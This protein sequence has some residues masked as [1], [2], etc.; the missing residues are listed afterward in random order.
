MIRPVPLRELPRLP[1]TGALVI[2][3]IGA[4][5]LE[6]TGRD[7]SALT[8]DVRA[9]ETEPWRL[10]T[11]ALPHVGVIH[12]AFNLYWIWTFGARVEERWGP[13]RTLILYA[14]LAVVS[15]AAE[16]VFFRGGVGLSGVGYGLFGLLWVVH[17]RDPKLRD[18]LDAGTIR[19]F[20]LWFFACIGLTV[21]EILPI[22]NVAHGSGALL[23]ALIG[24]GVVAGGA[25]RGVAAAT[26]ALLTASTLVGAAFFRPLLNVS[27]HGGDAEARLGDDF[28]DE[29]DVESAIWRYRGA[30]AVS[31][32]NAR[33]WHN[34]GV[35][36]QQADRYGESLGAYERALAIEAD[37]PR[38]REAVQHRSS[39]LGWLALEADHPK[40]AVTFLA[41]AVELDPEDQAAATNLD[42]ARAQV[43]LG[44]RTPPTQRLLDPFED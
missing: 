35:A 12:L 8:L 22:A 19:L 16:H 27:A 6:L 2:G 18:A 17:T 30:V 36:L 34:L 11:S 33:A 23:G 9:F 15:G 26:V 3:T 5:V 7:L 24:W 37:T 13:A 1:V 38:Y 10:F 39:Y 28:L 25:K 40:E 41:R 29:G 32:T 14:A 43:G 21:T 31:P 44:K 42:I 20:V 4:A